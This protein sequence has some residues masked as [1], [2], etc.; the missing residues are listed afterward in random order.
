MYLGHC[1]CPKGVSEVTRVMG[2]GRLPVLVCAGITFMVTT[3]LDAQ[4][5]LSVKPVPHRQEVKQ[6]DVEIFIGWR[7]TTLVFTYIMTPLE[8]PCVF[9]GYNQDCLLNVSFNY[10]KKTTN[11]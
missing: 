10:C 4:P 2:S 9:T 7:W 11:N 3:S 6:N 5:A 1:Q 8:R